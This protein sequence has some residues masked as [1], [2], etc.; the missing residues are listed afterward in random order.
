MTQKHVR[1]ECDEPTFDGEKRSRS[2]KRK[3]P[4]TEQ[5]SNGRTKSGWIG[6]GARGACSQEREA[7]FVEKFLAKLDVV[8]EADAD[9]NRASKPAIEKLKMVP[10]LL[11]VLG[12]RGPLQ[13]AFL[14]RGVLSSLKNWLEPLPDGS[15]PNL[16]IRSALLKLLT[17]HLSVDAEDSERR[18]Q[19]KQS[20][21]GKAVMFL[22]KLP[23][24]SP[25]NKKLARHLVHKWSRPIFQKSTR[26]EDI[27]HYDAE[28]T[29]LPQQ[30]PV[31]P[32][33]VEAS[34]GRDELKVEFNR[35]Q[36]ELKPGDRGYQYPHAT[37][38]EADPQDFIT[39][40]ASKVKPWEVKAHRKELEGRY[41]KRTMR[42]KKLRQLALK[43]KSLQAVSLSVDGRGLLK[44][45]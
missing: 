30:M 31:K 13:S 40:P 12:N 28:M 38:P 18:D 19:L 36:S 39:R 27:G 17:N 34:G 6:L 20:G 42:H 25:E 4:D 29:P 32:R 15:V 24:E 2:S 44:I 7:L 45:F 35:V 43:K 10:E 26:F 9:L 1:D 41:K 8:A 5:E 16:N 3:S 11:R 21:L 33:G 23:E 14:D 22:S 37:I